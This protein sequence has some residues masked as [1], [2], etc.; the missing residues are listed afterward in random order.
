MLGCAAASGRLPNHQMP[1][2][3]RNVELFSQAE[4][5]DPA[6]MAEIFRQAYLIVLR[7]INMNNERK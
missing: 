4:L 2:I 6:T 7:D 5:S 1:P 3:S